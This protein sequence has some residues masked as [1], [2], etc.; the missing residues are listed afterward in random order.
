MDP[1]SLGMDVLKHVTVT[2]SCG[3]GAQEWAAAVGVNVSGIEEGE[4]W[5]E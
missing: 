2:M 1:L 5:K 4:K 3:A